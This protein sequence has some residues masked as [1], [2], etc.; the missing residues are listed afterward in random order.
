[1]FLSQFS[2]GAAQVVVQS[3]AKQIVPGHT[4][5]QEPQFCSSSPVRAQAPP[6]HASVAPQA[7]EHAPQCVALLVRSTHAPSQHE[8]G[9][10]RP[11]Q[12]RASASLASLPPSA[13]LPPAS[14][15]PSD[16]AASA[17]SASAAPSGT[18]PPPSRPL[19][20]PAPTAPPAPPPESAG[21]PAPPSVPD[22]PPVVDASAPLLPP[23]PSG[24]AAGSYPLKL[25]L[26]RTPQPPST[27]AIASA[28]TGPQRARS[29]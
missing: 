22:R 6:Q 7:R 12:G 29:R 23:P 28:R 15:P 20:P 4:F 13:S 10:H 11:P 16:G 18:R 3:P 1:M 8:A 14:S 5:P 25:S 19:P 9:L 26:I 21:R 27:D 2:W 24:D 17:A